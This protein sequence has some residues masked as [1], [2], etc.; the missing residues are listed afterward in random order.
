MNEKINIINRDRGVTVHNLDANEKV[1]VSKPSFR[2]RHSSVIGHVIIYADAERL[3]TTNMANITIQEG[4]TGAPVQLTPDNFDSLTDGLTESKGGAGGGPGIDPVPLIAAHNVSGSA[5]EDIRLL[6]DDVMERL[7]GMEGL[8][9][10]LDDSFTTR[11]AVPDNIS[12]FP[13]DASPGDFVIVRNDETQGGASTM[14]MIAAVTAGVI[15]W[16]LGVV[17]DTDISGKVS[18][19]GDVMTGDLVAKAFYDVEPSGTPER[20]YSPNNPPPGI[21]DVSPGVTTPQSRLPGAWTDTNNVPPKVIQ[22]VNRAATVD[23]EIKTG[24]DYTFIADTAGVIINVTDT[25]GAKNSTL[26]ILTN[27][28]VFE[29][30]GY[31]PANAAIK[32]Y[33]HGTKWCL[34]TAKYTRTI[35]DINSMDLY[36]ATTLILVKSLREDILDRIA[37]ISSRVI[38]LTSGV[39]TV[40]YAILPYIDYVFIRDNT[41]SNIAVTDSAGLKSS[42]LMV[43]HES[44]AITA[45]RTYIAGQPFKAFWNNYQW[46]MSSGHRTPLSG[47]MNASSSFAPHVPLLKSKYDELKGDIAAVDAIARGKARAKVFASLSDFNTWVSTTGNLDT[48]DIGDLFFIEGDNSIWLMWD[49]TSIVEFEY[50]PVDLSGFYDKEEI[51]YLLLDYYTKTEAYSTFVA[52]LA[53]WGLSQNNFNSDYKE[54]LDWGGIDDTKTGLSAMDVTKRLT[55]VTASANQTFTMASVAASDDAYV[56]VFTAGAACTVAIPPTTSPLGSG[57]YVNMNN[58]SLYSLAAG[59]MLEI[60]GFRNSKTGNHHLKMITNN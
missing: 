51:D 20:V 25:V 39:A 21:T 58:E 17:F 34:S 30:S 33:W 47:D 11:D 3:Y 40:D 28:G 10:L 54:M 37:A 44:G 31:N 12:A 15:T 19:S 8:G 32:A 14:Y 13:P 4:A 56:I 41:G 27:N 52:K 35:S 22:L 50:A 18:K 53:G 23:F 55:T 24:V 46:V 26:Q 1:L 60:H 5:H 9:R 7:D 16:K 6:Y 43:M 57:G 29:D 59:D 48:V 2:I 36:N 38:E 49:G 45:N 42:T